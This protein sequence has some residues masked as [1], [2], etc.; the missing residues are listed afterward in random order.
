MKV[1]FTGR[2]GKAGSW[3]MRGLQMAE[4]R[5]DWRAVANCT[6]ADLRDTDV[7]VITKR[8]SDD[9]LAEIKKWGGKIVYDPLDFWHQPND[10]VGISS[11]EEVQLKFSKHFKNINANLTLACNEKMKH[12]LA[13][14]CR[15][16]E[17]L[18]HHYDPKLKAAKYNAGRTIVYWGHPRYLGEWA[19]K[20]SNV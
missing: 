15:R 3:Q 6:L 14:M 20:M 19:D 4:M 9:S 2:G 17:I 5:P 12:D 11:P 18:H 8:I 1:L 10:A 16:V 7:A 13:P